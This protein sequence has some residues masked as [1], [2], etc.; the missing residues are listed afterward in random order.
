MYVC[1][2]LFIN[3]HQTRPSVQVYKCIMHGCMYAC[4]YVGLRLGSIPLLTGVSA[5]TASRSLYLRNPA[6]ISAKTILTETAIHTYIHAASQP[7]MFIP[8]T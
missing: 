6:M 1:I 2:Y 7:A 3:V 8:T 5:E 4:M